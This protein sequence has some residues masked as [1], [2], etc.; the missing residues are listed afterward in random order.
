MKLKW[1]GITVLAVLGL[2][3]IIEPHD[4][5]EKQKPTSEEKV[6]TE[7]IAVEEEEDN[8]EV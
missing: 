2:G 8:E 1:V 7:N 4:Y 5:D 6:E 3:L